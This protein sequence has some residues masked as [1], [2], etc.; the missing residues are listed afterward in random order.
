MANF[1]PR[2]EKGDMQVLQNALTNLPLIVAALGAIYFL[3]KYSTAICTAIC[4]VVSK[5]FK[6]AFAHNQMHQNN[7]TEHQGINKRLDEILDLNKSESVCIRQQQDN[8]NVT[9]VNEFKTIHEQMALDR[10]KIYAKMESDRQ[11]SNA[12]L[13]DVVKNDLAIMAGQIE[14]GCNGPVKKR[15]A[16]LLEKLNNLAFNQE[17]K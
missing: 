4:R 11:W 2:K 13:H 14:Q 17:D 9:F 3:G 12:I 7:S 8:V 5:P 15:Y 16:E 6:V 1:E 10:E